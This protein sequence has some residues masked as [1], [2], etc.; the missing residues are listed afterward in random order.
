MQFHSPQRLRGNRFIEAFLR[1]P[2]DSQNSQDPFIK[3]LEKIEFSS[4]D[5]HKSASNYDRYML[6]H[7]SK[8]A[9][10]KG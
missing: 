7:L 4:S 5:V 3:F 6:A 9:E 8:N 1:A 2:T 10:L